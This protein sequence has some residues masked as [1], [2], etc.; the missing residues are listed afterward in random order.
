MAINFLSGIT[1]DSTVLHTDT[2]NDRVGIGT[3]SPSYT[4]DVDGVIRGEQYLRLADT[5]GT[6]QF[7][8][9][10][11]STYGTLDNGT[12]TFN[13]IANAHIFYRGGSEVMR[14]HTNNNIGIG[15]TSP[16]AKLDVNGGIRMA[17]DTSAASST[18]VGTLRYYTSGNNSYVDMCMQTGA[19]TYAWVNIVQN[20]W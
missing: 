11:E 14:V 6:N 1:V 9:R 18:N 16:V 15:T 20:S 10:A 5:T 19:A 4:L 3:T 2:T 13:Y 7:S 17:N 8:I 12:K